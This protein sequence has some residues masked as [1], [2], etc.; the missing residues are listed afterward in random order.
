MIHFS[1]YGNCD[2]HDYLHV[3][4]NDLKTFKPCKQLLI[5][6]HYEV[7]IELSTFQYKGSYQYSL[8]E[9]NGL[10]VERINFNHDESILLHTKLDEYN[11]SLFI[12]AM[13]DVFHVVYR[14]SF[15]HSFL[16]YDLFREEIE[17]IVQNSNDFDMISDLFMRHKPSG[18]EFYLFTGDNQNFFIQQRDRNAP[19]PEDVVMQMHRMFKPARIAQLFT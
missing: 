9:E 3:R 2:L 10:F 15:H 18:L 4:F 16:L 8:Y 19:L 1:P 7:A 12:S 13:L 14:G 5:T 11:Q 17:R 6:P